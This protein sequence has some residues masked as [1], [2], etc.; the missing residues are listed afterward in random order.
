MRTWSTFALLALAKTAWANPV[1]LSSEAVA[2]A[3]SA[4]L[5]QDG[6]V[7]EIT[8]S[9]KAVL[10]WASFSIAPGET[11]RFIQ[12]SSDSAVLNRVLGSGKRV[13]EILGLLESNGR[14]YL[15][16]QQGVLLGPGGVVKTPLFFA[17]TREIKIDSFVQGG[18]LP[19]AVEG[20]TGSIQLYPGFRMEGG[21]VVLA[22][23]KVKRSSSLN[24]DNLRIEEGPGPLLFDPEGSSL[25]YI[26]P[27]LSLDE[28]SSTTPS[29]SLALGGSREAPR[30]VLSSEDGRVWILGEAPSPLFLAAPMAPLAA[31]D[32]TLTSPV[33]VT[34]NGSLSATGLLSIESTGADVNL[35][36]SISLSATGSISL[37]AADTLNIGS[38]GSW[39]AGTT[40][41]ATGTL[42]FPIPAS[43]SIGAGSTATLTGPAGITLAGGGST[44]SLT[45]GSL[46]F[47]SPVS[48]AGGFT[49]NGTANNLTFQDSV[50]ADFIS[51]SAAVAVSVE[52]SMSTLFG[53]SGA[54]ISMVL[55]SSFSLSDNATVTANTGTAAG[56]LSI[57]ASAISLGDA[58]TVESFGP[59]T[60]IAN[61][62][63][64]ATG[65]TGTIQTLSPEQVTLVADNS[66]PN[67]PLFGSGSIS[68][69]PDFVIQVNSGVGDTPLAYIFS[70][71]YGDSQFPTEI[72]S[73]AYSPGT[74]VPGG[75]IRGTN[76]FVGYWYG[77]PVPSTSN[78]IILYKF[79][80]GIDFTP[81]L[82]AL[83]TAL[84]EAVDEPDDNP[85]NTTDQ[86]SVPKPNAGCVT[87]VSGVSAS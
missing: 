30:R 68:L 55:G 34:V 31:G 13:S 20:E 76:E 29:V 4:A 54:G 8:T 38:G 64:F 43:L 74:F 33:D 26:Q 66:F 19:L 60:L 47:A 81:D 12:P 45:G 70:S 27:D 28:L 44:L 16:N 65:T 1:P 18:A 63:I 49:V 58:S 78:F 85:E 80:L 56:P 32:I 51:F 15:Y 39:S 21:P 40:L 46:V 71:V 83:R 52:Q 87:P 53:G 75:F 11:T 3:G 77:Q 6:S 86:P 14:V 35:A 9:N 22:S 84:V 37:T 72:N 36:S 23:S 42:A 59:L 82:Q 61:G 25:L 50:T 41:A 24:S 57:T 62:S 67:P 10:D 17:T 7:L 73:L 2:S 48:G 69:P 79:A 5:H